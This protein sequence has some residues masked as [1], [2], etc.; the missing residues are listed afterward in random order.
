[1]PR[2][3]RNSIL[4]DPSADNRIVGH[5][6]HRHEKGQDAEEFPLRI[7]RRIGTDGALL[8]AS[9]DRDVG[10]QQREAEGQHQHEIDQ[11]EEPTAVLRCEV[12]ETPEI[13]D[14]DGTA[15]RRKD[16]SDLS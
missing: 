14:A 12:R 2:K 3:I 15:G 1:M 8:R 16:E 10:G 5:D 6:Q 9:S 7:H 11:Q 13:T 4:R